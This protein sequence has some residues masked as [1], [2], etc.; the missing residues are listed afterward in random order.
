[1]TAY[2]MSYMINRLVPI[3]MTLMFV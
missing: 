2:R 3:R 1:L